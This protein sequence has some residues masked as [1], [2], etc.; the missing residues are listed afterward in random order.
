M[1]SE[2][3]QKLKDIAQQIDNLDIKS[4]DY[5]Y[6]LK[7]LNKLYDRVKRDIEY[8]LYNKKITKEEIQ[9]EENETIELNKQ[10]EESKLKK[11]IDELT[12]KRIALEKM[13]RKEQGEINEHIGG[14]DRI[15]RAGFVPPIMPFNYLELK[16]N[17]NK[18]NLD[19]ILLESKS[20]LQKINKN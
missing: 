4:N 11:D 9:S 20:L 16:E 1:D 3:T 12:K 5:D 6:K 8:K 17:I 15:Q 10:I 18:V 14:L 13:L 7:I 19:S 2:K